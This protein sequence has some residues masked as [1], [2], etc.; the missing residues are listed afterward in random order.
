MYVILD[1]I[2][3]SQHVKRQRC[4]SENLLVNDGQFPSETSATSS[5]D[6]GPGGGGA[7]ENT[8]T[9]LT[10]PKRRQETTEEF[11]QCGL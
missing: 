11:S 7:G 6:L 4:L 10:P 8:T 9:T 1:E 5:G 3:T 2:S